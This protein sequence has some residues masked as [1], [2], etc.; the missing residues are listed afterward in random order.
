[1]PAQTS[2]AGVAEIGR[3]CRRDVVTIT[4][5]QDVSEAAHLM[6]SRHVGFIVVCEPGQSGEPG[7]PGRVVG[8][9]TDRDIVVAVIARDVAPRSLKIAD[10]M[11]R[12]PLIV[13]EECPIDS[14]LGFMRDAGVRRVP[15]VGA[16]ERLVG[17]VSLDD[18][19]ERVAQ[20]LSSIVA[21]YR[22]EERT[23]RVTRP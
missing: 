2:T 10:V 16:K 7:E 9:I 3:I 1:M 19:V 13:S 21:A 4:P 17:V 5:V 18:V 15:V 22:G 6:R 23:E 11:T 8:V 14:A 20:Q 12:N